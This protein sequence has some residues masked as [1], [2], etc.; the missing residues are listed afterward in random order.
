MKKKIIGR[1]QEIKT[2]TEALNSNQPEFVAVVG[3]R[4]VGK[5]FMIKQTYKDYIRFELTGLQ[6]SKKH[7]QLQN[8]HFAFLTFFPDYELDKK[9]TSW[10]EAFFLLSRAL[11]EE[12]SSEKKVIFLDEIPWLGTKRSGFIQGLGWLWNSWAVNRNVVLI[13]CGSAASWMIEKVINDRG[14]LHNRVTQSIFLYPFSLKETDQF[15]HLKNI[16]LSRYQIVQLYMTMGGIPMYLNQLKPGLSAIQNIQAICF[17]KG[18]Y[19]K[20]EFDR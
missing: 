6:K 10:L 8:F 7:E 19:L 14:G 12:G 2:L 3:R 16:R 13:I 17:D 5:T 20:K 9:P 15:L 1:T 4:R 11:D 18:G